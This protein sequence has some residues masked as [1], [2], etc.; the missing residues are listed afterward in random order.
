MQLTLEQVR[1]VFPEVRPSSSMGHEEYY[2]HCRERHKKGGVY[3]M[4]INA[5]TGYYYCHDCGTHGNAFDDFFSQTSVFMPGRARIIRDSST[6]GAESTVRQYHKKRIWKGEVPLPGKMQTALSLEEGHPAKEYLIKERGLSEKD[7]DDFHL[8]YCTTGYFK[9]ASIGTTAGRIVFPLYMCDELIGWQARYL[10][11]KDS[12]G[13]KFVWNEAIKDWKHIPMGED[14]RYE[15]FFIP[16]YYMPPGMPRSRALLNYDNAKLASRD[17]VVVVEGPIDCMKVGIHGIATLG[18]TIT[19]QQARI[20]KA[21]WCNIIWILD[22][23]IDTEGEK[24]KRIL[25][26]LEQ[27]GNHVV[28]MKMDGVH[29]PGDATHK[30]IAEQ[31]KQKSGY[32]L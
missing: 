7:I 14:G 1:S 29:D 21:C 24:F 18:S 23:E 5:D 11:K 27:D 30:Q 16:K 25:D 28:Y 15:D 10:E 26:D 17:F 4:S 3:K 2:V 13:K 9:V 22:S 6:E 32:K 12:K 20:I 31:V 19:Q 8:E